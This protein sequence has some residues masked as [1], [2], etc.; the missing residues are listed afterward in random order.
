VD[1]AL[2]PWCPS[3]ELSGLQ[4]GAH[5]LRLSV[6]R[7]EDGTCELD[8]ESTPGLEIVQGTPPWLELDT[9]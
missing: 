2:P 1:P 5:E 3:F 9:S 7:R 6:R 4:L 8:A